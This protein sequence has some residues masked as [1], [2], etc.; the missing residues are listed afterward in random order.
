MNKNN[1]INA[2]SIQLIAGFLLFGLAVLREL[3]V[4]GLVSAFV[5]VAYWL[6]YSYINTKYVIKYIFLF[7]SMASY[8]VGSIMCDYGSVYQ[9][10]IGTTTR[11]VG[12]FC[13]L[14][15]LFWVTTY[16]IQ[17]LDEILRKII[18]RDVK[19]NYLI[20]MTSLTCTIKKYAMFFV[21][22]I[23]VLFFLLVV[24]KPSFA[25]NINR[26]AYAS[27]MPKW[28]YKMR[29]IPILLV[30]IVFFSVSDIRNGQTVRIVR[31][32]I[33]TYVPFCLF[34][35]WIGD[36]NGIFI[37][38][39]VAFVIP[40]AE[41]IDYSKIKFRLLVKIGITTIGG[42]AI[43]LILFWKLRGIDYSQMFA[44]FSTR[45]SQQGELWWAVVNNGEWKEMRLD[46]FED[47]LVNIFKSFATAGIEKTYG[48]YRLMEMYGN[49]SYL[50]HYYE[51]DMRLSAMGFE[52]M[53]YFFGV[54]AYIIYPLFTNFCYALITNLYSNALY[55]RSLSA[56]VYLRIFIVL[57]TALM[58]GDWYRFGSKLDLFLIAFL[59]FDSMA[60]KSSH[61]AEI[62]VRT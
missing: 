36:K 37:T 50:K 4:A 44:K 42:L 3:R 45:V 22:A 25:L 19:Y 14:A 60:R 57:Q 12:S 54:I 17:F 16:S 6:Y 52:L 48:V 5:L 20:G 2:T 26:F 34:A 40:L 1:S 24:N 21:F 56:V 31:R 62:L 7:I 13:L 11:Y 53:F 8:A 55:N 59:I 38:L 47:E 23:G 43:I 28:L 49:K 9:V 61:K 27:L 29:T 32:I 35:F 10:E 46:A 51:I 41:I 33:A 18:Y 15:P 58:Q 30:P 39:I